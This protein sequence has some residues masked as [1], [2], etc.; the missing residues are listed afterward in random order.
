MAVKRAGADYFRITDYGLL[1][2]DWE[3]TY[4]QFCV[5]ATVTAVLEDGRKLTAAVRG[6][7]EVNIYME[8]VFAGFEKSTLLLA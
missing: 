2:M 7:S 3:P 6:Y 8:T 1:Q 4:V 5:T